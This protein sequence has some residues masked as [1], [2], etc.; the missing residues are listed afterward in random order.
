VIHGDHGSGW[1]P[2]DGRLVA[3]PSGDLRTLLLAKPA[4]A[5]GPMRAGLRPA[6]VIDIAPTLLGL[7]GVARD[8]ELDGRVLE[9]VAP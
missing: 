9:D 4:G 1:V 8:R 3:D 5:R 7:A 2:K 6:S